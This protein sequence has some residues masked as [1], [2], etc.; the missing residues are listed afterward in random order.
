MASSLRIAIVGAGPA[1][2]A[3]ALLL[4]R[5]GHRV[6]ILEKFDAPKPLG[7]G[8]IH[9]WNGPDEFEIGVMRS[10][11]HAQQGKVIRFWEGGGG[12]WQDPKTRPAE[13]VLEDVV[14]EFVS[15]AAARELYG[16]EVRC[17]DADAALS[18]HLLQIAKTQAVGQIPA[19]A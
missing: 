5:D 11:V 14:D 2:L 7:S 12:G 17:V 13:W 9:D 10:G 16:V 6:E 3:A 8:L 1:G 18:H 4:S 19:H 15:I